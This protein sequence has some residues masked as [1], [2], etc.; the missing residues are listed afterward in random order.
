MAD[1]KITELVELNATPDDVD[2]LPI[3]DDVAVTPVTKKI[4][5]ANLL[6]GI[7]SDTA[8]LTN[9]RITDRVTEI[10]THATPTVDTDVCD[11]VSITAL[12]EDITSMTTNLSGTETNFQKIIFRI[13]DDGTARAIAWGSDFEA[14]GVALPT[15]TVAGKTLLVGFIYDSVDSKWAC[16]ASSSRA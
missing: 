6:G 7:N 15:T 5:V 12:A 13:L 10:T 14:G 4:T 9:K 1:K 2:I 16:E 3:V 8:T 11:V